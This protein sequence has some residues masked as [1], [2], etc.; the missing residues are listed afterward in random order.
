MSSLR[1]LLASLGHWLWLP[2]L[3]ACPVTFQGCLLSNLAHAPA[4]LV[5]VC[6]LGASW[7]TF[8]GFWLSQFSAFSWML[9]VA[10]LGVLSSCNFPGMLIQQFGVAPTCLVNPS[11]LLPNPFVP[12]VVASRSYT[13]IASSLMIFSTITSGKCF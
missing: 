3:S 10:A 12:L 7:Q 5:I 9:I 13:S 1:G 4:C 11:S 8:L 6:A 2:F